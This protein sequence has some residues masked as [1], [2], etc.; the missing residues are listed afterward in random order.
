MS[1][2]RLP[3]GVLNAESDD[4]SLTILRIFDAPREEVFKAWTD[5][6]RFARWFGEHGSSVPVDAAAMDV[7]PGGAWRAVMI[8]GPEAGLVFSGHY[9]EVDEPSHLVLTITDQ[10][11][12]GAEAFEV[13]T[14][15]LE[16]LGDGHTQM[17][18]SQRGGNLPP[19][20]YEVTL[21]GWLAFFDR[22]ADLLKGRHD[23][24]LKARHDS[25]T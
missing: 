11:P 1:D 13:L 19:D 5:P 3:D 2:E 22:K 16:D 18:F 17:T 8:V 21:R 10:E 20:Q 4:E 24:D 12:V 23:T 7:R 15:D 14:V 25:E 6:G 9:R